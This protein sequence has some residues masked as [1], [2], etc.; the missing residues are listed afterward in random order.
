[1]DKID[2]LLLT[3]DNKIEFIK[4]LTDAL[5]EYFKCV[6]IENLPE[7][8]GTKHPWSLLNLIQDDK[9]DTYALL[10]VNDRVWGASGGIVRYIDD[11]KI[12]QGGFRWFS[13]AENLVK[14]LGCMKSYLYT[15]TMVDQLQRAREQDCDKFT[16]SFND[17]NERFFEITKK[18]HLRKV[19]PN[20]VFNPSD[21][22]VMFNGVPQRLLTVDLK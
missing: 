10:Y 22:L 17:Y 8:Y 3:A 15:Y 20:T 2:V 6:D 14:G 11:K 4:K 5:F 1:M 13:N 12:Y 16:L 9:I 7:N 19:F 18:Y 21:G